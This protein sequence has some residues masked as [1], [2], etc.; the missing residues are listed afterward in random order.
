MSF[1]TFARIRPPPTSSV[2][3]KGPDVFPYELTERNTLFRIL[4]AD[5]EREE[6]YAFDRVFPPTASQ[7][8]LYD[9]FGTVVVKRYCYVMFVCM[10]VCNCVVRWVVSLCA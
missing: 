5:A 9:C 3:S 2:R 4:D 1:S 8:D 10:Y 7:E 6:P